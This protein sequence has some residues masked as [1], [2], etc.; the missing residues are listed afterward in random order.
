MIKSTLISAT[1]LLLGFFGTAQKP[2]KQFN[3]LNE[4][5]VII[6]G[7]DPVAFFTDGKPVAGSDKF[8]YTYEGAKYYFASQEHLDQFKS[9]PE[10]YK[11]QFGGWC[12]YAVSLGRVAP[13][14]VNFWS[15]QDGRLLFQHNKRADE[16]WKKNPAENLMLADKYWPEVSSKHGEQIVTESEKAFY[17]NTD[18]KGVAIGG[19]DPVAYFTS[20]KALKGDK[21]YEARFEGATYH[22]TSQDNAETFK[23]NPRMFAPLYGGFCGYAMSDGGRRRPVNPKLFSIV[24]GHLILQ[25]S[26]GA[27]QLW[28]KDVT[29][30]KEKADSFWPAVLEKHHGQKTMYD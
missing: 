8:N 14:D 13:I 4:K 29:Q 22:F 28:N 1:V 5:G 12:A 15:I 25:H 3:N 23:N 18:E 20:N 16:G 6:G 2:L 27:V 26:N 17:N 10:K 19:Y 11:P 24:D 9:D 30:S 7:Y 21:K